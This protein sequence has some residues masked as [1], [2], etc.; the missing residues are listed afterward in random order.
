MVI[1]AWGPLFALLAL[2]GASLFGLLGVEHPE[3]H[4]SGQ[5]AVAPYHNRDSRKFAATLDHNQYYDKG[6]Q[7]SHWVEQIFEKPTDTLLVIFNGLLVLF[8]YLLYYATAGLF[9]E[10]AGLRIAADQ[11][12]ADMKDTISAA[13]DSA[14]AAILAVG[15]ERAWIC[16]ETVESFP[17]FNSR[18]NEI[19]FQRA[20]GFSVRW[21]NFGRTPAIGVIIF[22]DHRIIN[23]SDDT[24]IFEEDIPVFGANWQESRGDFPVG[25]G[26]SANSTPRAIGD[27]ELAAVLSGSKIMFLYS[28]VKYTDIFNSTTRVSEVCLR[29]QGNGMMQKK[30]IEVPNWRINPVGKQNTTR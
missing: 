11:Q 13:R 25:P 12:A 15:T 9:R 6:E 10:T 18:I 2:F 21:K 14:N 28:A 16:F 20:V 3:P 30:G 7:K 26:A 8:T 29:I 27:L 24:P 1:K 22:I 17:S 4:S 23:Q 19:S 5:P